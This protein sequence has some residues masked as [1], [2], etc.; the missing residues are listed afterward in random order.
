MK[1][2]DLK[3]NKSLKSD[4]PL[5]RIS[6][7]YQT[8]TADVISQDLAESEIVAH[9]YE[10]KKQALQQ[11]MDEG[12][13]SPQVAWRVKSLIESVDKRINAYKKR[14]SLMELK[15]RT[16][17]VPEPLEHGE[18]WRKGTIHQK[19]T[20]EIYSYGVAKSK[21]DEEQLEKLEKDSLLYDDDIIY[22]YDHLEKHFP[23]EFKII[24]QK[25]KTMQR[26]NRTN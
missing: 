8:A 21:K 25:F 3:F 2:P 17:V 23:E 1:N 19:T 4:E 18:E 7:D 16:L 15:Q 20:E 13:F 12:K 9:T 10:V 14:K 5:A 22:M 6:L 24:D 11:L 26:E